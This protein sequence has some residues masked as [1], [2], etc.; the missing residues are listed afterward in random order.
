MRLADVLGVAPQTIAHFF[1][2]ADLIA[3]KGVT[4]HAA[5]LRTVRMRE[6]MTVSHLTAETGIPRSTL[7]NYETGRVRLPHHQA[8]VLATAMSLD[9]DDFVQAL[10]EKAPPSHPR[11]ITPLR[12]LRRRTGLTQEH[13]AARLGLTR[14]TL[15]VWERNLATPSVS[16]VRE[17]SRIYGVPVSRV[18]AAA[19]VSAPEGLDRTRW[20]RGDL[21]TVLR[22]LRE[23]SGLTQR[24]LAERCGCHRG[25]VGA[26]ETGETVPS[27]YFR[28]RLEEIFRLSPEDLLPVYPDEQRP[29]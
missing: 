23:W 1:R 5:G 19:G 12:L 28:V 24:E 9:L 7:Y 20:R 26:W 18:A 13:V 8:S 16:V 3:S 27:R 29:P 21:P 2:S 22:A 11:E 6:G 25:T 17:L 4:L 10:R 15:A 14:W